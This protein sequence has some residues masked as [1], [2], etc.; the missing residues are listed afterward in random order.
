MLIA[1]EVLFCCCLTLALVLLGGWYFF[2][3]L[4]LVFVLGGNCIGFV[5]FLHFVFHFVISVYEPLV[6]LVLVVLINK[7]LMI[8]KKKKRTP[9]L[10]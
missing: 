9:Y 10:I 3:C 8:Q 1:G 7:I 2:L 4:A 6:L 5:P